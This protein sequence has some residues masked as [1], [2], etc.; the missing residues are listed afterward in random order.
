M[1]FF[2]WI[3]W[4]FL[5]KISE[6]EQPMMNEVGN[7]IGV[8]RFFQEE[9]K[10]RWAKGIILRNS[11]KYIIFLIAFRLVIPFWTP[12]RTSLFKGYFCRVYK[13][14]KTRQWIGYWITWF[15]IVFRDL[16]RLIIYI[17]YENC[18]SL[19]FWIQVGSKNYNRMLKLRKS[20]S[21]LTLW[22]LDRQFKSQSSLSW[23]WIVF[24]SINP[25]DQTGWLPAC[26]WA[27]IWRSTRLVSI[28]WTIRA[29]L[30]C[31]SICFKLQMQNLLCQER[32]VILLGVWYYCN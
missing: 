29:T 2:M 22:F 24:R 5:M 6:P 4:P 23:R 31:M 12:M 11:W 32:L 19:G 16:Y 21:L 9:L 8:G 28:E 3:G 30:G 20:C 10:V 15:S 7:V 26:Q 17:I 27:R 14:P 25:S 1:V 13:C 18:I